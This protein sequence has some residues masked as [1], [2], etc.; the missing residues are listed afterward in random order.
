MPYVCIWLAWLSFNIEM[1]HCTIA[2][3]NFDGK[4]AKASAS[5]AASLAFTSSHTNLIGQWFI[6]VFGLRICLSHI[7]LWYW[8]PVHTFS[9]QFHSMSFVNV[10]LYHRIISALLFIVG[11]WLFTSIYHCASAPNSD[12]LTT[13]EQTEQ[14]FMAEEEEETPSKHI[15]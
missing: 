6:N 3:G 7:S 4:Q 9:R 5:I 11:M 1:T 8:H 12:V 2:L 15:K 13:S 14:Q 10:N